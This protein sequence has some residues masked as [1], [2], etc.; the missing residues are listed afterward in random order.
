MA[1]EIKTLGYAKLFQELNAWKQPGFVID[2]LNELCG[3]H[4]LLVDVRERPYGLLDIR[5]LV[6]GLG[7]SYLHVPSLGN[8]AYKEN[9][10]VLEGF[11]Y[12]KQMMMKRGK[13]H[14]ILMCAEGD[15]NICHRREVAILMKREIRLM[16]ADARINHLYAEGY[17]DTKVQLDILGF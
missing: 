8:P 13:R 16:G 15:P 9:G 3:D 14:F 2:R 11:K 7:L 10:A 17:F 12:I 1:I 4:T 6:K 5:Q